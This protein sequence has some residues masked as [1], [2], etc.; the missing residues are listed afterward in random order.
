[1]EKFPTWAYGPNGKS[2]IFERAEDI[3]AGWTDHP[4]KVKAAAPAATKPTAPA[5]PAADTKPADTPSDEA[6]DV[7]A[8]GHPYDPALHAATRSKTSAGLWRMKVGVKRPEPC[9]PPK[10]LDL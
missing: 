2:G 10:T 9:T 8:D 4:S 1:M 5:A 3:P 7:D 6:A